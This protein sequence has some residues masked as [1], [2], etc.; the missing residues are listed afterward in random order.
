MKR[1]TV[2]ATVVVATASFAA[3]VARATHSTPRTKPTA[4][5]ST[6]CPDALPSR[7]NSPAVVEAISAAL[8]REVPVVYAKKRSQGSVA[9]KNY[10]VALVAPLLPSWLPEPKLTKNYRRAVERRCGASLAEASWVVL[11]DFP[12]CTIPCSQSVAFLARRRSGWHIW[13]HIDRSP[14]G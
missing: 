12:E 2:L 7:R 10:Q 5:Q 1:L 11:L 9:W 4:R 6:A 13:W 14:N 8:T 3:L